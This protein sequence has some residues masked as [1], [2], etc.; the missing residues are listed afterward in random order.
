MT[1]RQN[2][3]GLFEH[4]RERQAR[5]TA[6][7]AERMRPAIFDEFVGQ[8][9]I[10]GADRVLRRAIEID[11]VPSILFWGRRVRARRRWPG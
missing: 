2:A 9:H 11:R 1:G 3:G 8:E 5:E 7:L 4:G 6:P 10:L